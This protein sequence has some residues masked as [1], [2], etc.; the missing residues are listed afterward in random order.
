MGAHTRN[1]AYFV[2]YLMILH[3]LLAFVDC[4]VHTANQEVVS[5]SCPLVCTAIAMNGL[6]FDIVMPR[7]F[8]SLSHTYSNLRANLGLKLS[9]RQ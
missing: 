4:L 8:C 9:L 2:W 3:R 5:H 1:V 6:I 7:T